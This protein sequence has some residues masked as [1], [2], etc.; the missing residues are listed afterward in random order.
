MGVA[1]IILV[2][3]GVGASLLRKLLPAG[4]LWFTLHRGFNIMG[5]ALTII[6]FTLAVVASNKEGTPHFQTNSHQKIGLAIFVLAL[7]QA[8]N[9]ILRPHAPSSAS[10]TPSVLSKQ[11]MDSGKDNMEDAVVVTD[12]NIGNNTHGAIIKTQARLI[13]EIG[14]RL[15]GVALLGLAWYN[16][17]T[18]VNKF[19]RFE[20]DYTVLLWSIVGAISGCIL[21]LGLYQYAANRPLSGMTE[22]KKADKKE[23]NLIEV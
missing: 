13:W 17:Y 23:N 20:D 15:F 21:T 8:F 4:G 3:L 19:A 22:V 7:G 9:G 2:P 5:I 14:H 12:Q 10:I 18:G 16:C 1:W 6:G 11:T